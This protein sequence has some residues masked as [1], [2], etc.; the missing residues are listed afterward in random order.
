MVSGK[1][2]INALRSVE[3]FKFIIIMTEQ[4]QQ[5][6]VLKK[7]GGI[8][9]FVPFIGIPVIIASV[10]IK[11]AGFLLDTA[12]SVLGQATSALTGVFCSGKTCS[13]GS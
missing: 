13:K 3:H 5:S 7:V 11:V 4:L 8:L 9:M 6:D 1:V 2:S 12:G 10:G